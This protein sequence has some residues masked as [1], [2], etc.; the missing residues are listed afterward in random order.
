MS[1][2]P[3]FMRLQNK[4]AIITG[5]AHGI[6][7]ATSFRFAEEG[8]QVI[9]CDVDDLAGRAAESEVQK[10]SPSSRFSRLDVADRS[11]VDTQIRQLRDEYKHLDILINNAG[12]TA[13]AQFLKMTEDQWDR[14]VEVNLKGVFN[15]T[16]SVAAV[17]VQQGWGKIVNAASMAGVY[18]NFGQ[19]NYAATK[20]GVIGMTRVWARELGRQG[21]CVNAVAPGF[22][23]TEMTQ[24]VPE[25]I[26]AIVTQKTPLG[27]MGTPRDVANVYLFLAS[28]ESDFI[29]GAVISVD[30]GLVI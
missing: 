28:N 20:A 11:L 9:L 22:I 29:N 18:G 2:K 6:G 7:L 30:G 4:V 27:R 26:R 14:V 23:D 10:I 15:C 1:L 12:V 24:K 21:I 3:D 19:T 25:K 5:A 16:Q 8:A 17:M 13:D